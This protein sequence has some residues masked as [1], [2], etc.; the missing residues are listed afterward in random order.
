MR[1][2][3]RLTS[4][5]AC[6]VGEPGDLSAHIERAA[7]P[8]RASEVPKAKRVLELNPTHPLLTRLQAF[9][10]ARPDRPSAS[11]ATRSCCYGQA[12]L[13]EGGTLPDPAAFSRQLAELLVEAAGDR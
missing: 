3:S 12:I 4:S 11:G 8:E 2:S 6:L 13:A 10:A 5:P 9:H 1:L 7:P